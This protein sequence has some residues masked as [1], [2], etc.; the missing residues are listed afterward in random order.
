MKRTNAILKLLLHTSFSVLFALA[1]V[2]PA[3]AQNWTQLSPSG[4]PPPG[5]FIHTAVYDTGTN[6]MIVFGG[7]NHGGGAGG[8]CVGTTCYNDVWVQSNADGVGGASVWTQLSP[9]G[10]A[11]L[12]RF[13]PTAVYDQ[14][15]NNMIVFGGGS[16]AS[17][18]YFGG[19]TGQ[20]N[21]TWVLANA[22]GSGGTP[23]WT[24]TAS[25][26]GIPRQSHLAVYDASS[27]RMVIFGGVGD[28]GYLA[29]L[30]VLSNA[31]G[32][33]G[34]PTWTQLSPAGSAPSNRGDSAAVY[35][36]ANNRMI[37]FGGNGTPTVV[38]PG[39]GQCCFQVFNEVWVLSNA[40][41]LGGAPTWTQ[42]A[43]TGGAPSARAG[44]S[45]VYNSATNTMTIFG[46]SD[47]AGNRFSDIW[48]LS[49]AN[50]LGG[51]PTWTQLSPPGGPGARSNHT[52]TYHQS[53]DR[54]TI[55]GGTQVTDPTLGPIGLNDAWV[56]SNA[57]GDS[58]EA[59]LNGGNTFTGNQ[60]VNG[61][62]TAT[63]F[64]GDGSG[65]TNVTAS[66]LNCA[67]CIGNSQL[68]V[69]YALGDSRGGSA[70]NALMLGNVAAANYA[71]L[72]VAT[73]QSF[74]G[75]LT[76]P[77]LALPSTTS[78][79]SG[80][81]D[82]NGSS[83]IHAFGTN[84]TFIGSNAG[85]FATSGNNLT[86]I[87]WNALMLNT[88]GYNNT[89]GGSFALASNTTGFWN[90][91]YG[92]YA[93]QNNTTGND[94]VAIGVNALVGNITGAVNTAVG[95][96]TLGQNTTGFYNT[97]IGYAA[98]E[99]SH[100]GSH[101][102]AMGFQALAF[103]TAGNSN[104]AVGDFAGTTGNSA[105][106]NTTGSNNTFIGNSSGPGTSAQLNNATAIGANALVS[107]SNSMVLGD[108][109]INVG[110]GTQT[111]SQALEVVG[112]VKA[113]SFS[114]SGAGLT[115]VTA[116]NATLLSLPT[117]TSATSG[118]ID[119]DGSSFI[120]AFGTRDT[121]VGSNAGNFS[122]SGNNLTAIGWNALMLNS[123]GTN[124][125]AGGAFA[126][127]N[128]TTGVSNTANGAG[129]LQS[130]SSGSGNTAIGLSA[131]TSN[132]ASVENTA[133]GIQALAYNTTGNSNTALGPYAG[134]TATI[135]NANTT[136]SNNTFIGNRSGPGTSTQLNNATAIG[137]NALVSQSNSM[138]LG[139]GTINVGIGTQTP[140]QALDVVGTVKATS[141]TGNG[142]GLTGVVATGINCAGCIGNAQLGVNYAGSS[143]QGGVATGAISA[144]QAA[145][146]SAL[147]GVPSGN[148]A[149]L[150]VGNSFTG[151]QAISGNLSA[152]GFL[153]IGGGTA[154][155][156]HLSIL[157]NPPFPAL[158][159]GKCAT[160]SFAFNGS[161]DG[162]TIALGVP[163]SR[164][165]GGGNLI[166]TAWISAANTVTVQ[167]CDQTT[168][169]T[170]AGTG[171]IRIDLW[172]H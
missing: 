66:L 139:D 169:Q 74:A 121:F 41:G 83:F 27:N 19:C 105:N 88:S 64:V 14:S 69:N 39:E 71:R 106:A 31:N 45:A 60:I 75:S 24:Q 65:L 172:K 165:S 8:P 30:W 133:G 134:V 67:G 54:M 63:S 58:G 55:F 28:C 53:T 159:S 151:N 150:D 98:M 50:G 110:I 23:T 52:A 118:V 29:D 76:M 148:Y 115:N 12:P 10:T 94:N 161:N 80:V 126:L 72:D 168:A 35:D 163:N 87:G 123:S 145:N 111:P 108:G 158:R 38:P 166:Y 131:L 157:V 40:N 147:G 92:A 56:L 86:A 43:P 16:D 102:N 154:I 62:V 13:A 138:V 122:T 44:M 135:G 171:S 6:A 141:L 49:S 117:T 162:D 33:G 61:I 9:S 36:M 15:S 18:P 99:V 104:T 116:S 77:V 129:A 101:N 91:A 4:G 47:V 90:T 51:T 22:N 114:G 160:A 11:P 95:N 85:N 5:R 109:T 124:N 144:N 107:Q 46:G 20:F 32:S 7:T 137:A 132:T 142:A 143:T 81:I 26:P 78:S 128:N 70:V 156:E 100:T 103:N 140:T 89:A 119:L 73:N 42:L 120:H 59:Q 125:T 3:S 93:L 1:L 68:G 112:T 82:L 164:M 146:A 113:I 84:D 127:N 79:T 130:N 167:A 152:S 57:N 136:G 96:N 97:A 170:A 34:T 2:C 17:P 21:D 37:I 153:T 149:R 25:F 155:K 48:Q